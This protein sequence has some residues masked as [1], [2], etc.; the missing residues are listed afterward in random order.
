[1]ATSSTSG[2]SRNNRASTFEVQMWNDHDFKIMYNLH[3]TSEE[4]CFSLLADSPFALLS[5]WKINSIII[6]F[7]TDFL[8]SNHFQ[9]Q[10][11]NLY[12]QTLQV[13]SVN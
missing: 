9:M 6:Y 4:M 10:T 13:N 2:N 1:M 7:A 12:S 8:A 11:K 5:S 3:L